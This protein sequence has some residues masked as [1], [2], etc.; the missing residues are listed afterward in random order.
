MIKDMEKTSTSKRILGFPDAFWIGYAIMVAIFL[1]LVFDIQHDYAA[2]TPHVGKWTELAHG[3]A[4]SG[5]LGVIQYYFTYHHLPD[6]SPMGTTG[7]ADPPLFYI[8]CAGIL[9]LIH[10]MGGWA[11]GT[12]LHCISCLNAIFTMIGTFCG[13]GLL[14]KAGIRGRELVAAILFLLFFPAYY[15]LGQRL[16]GDAM[17]FMFC[18]LAL[19]AAAG[20][21][22]TRRKRTLIFASVFYGLGTLTSYAAF[23][24][25]PA[26]IAL[27]VLAVRDGRTEGRVFRSQVIPSGIVAGVMSLVWPVYNLIRFGVPLFYSG[28]PEG[29]REVGSGISFFERVNPLRILLLFDPE[30]VNAVDSGV[31]I[32]LQ[33][34]RSAF[35]SDYLVTFNEFTR[36]LSKVYLFLGIFVILLMHILWIWALFTDS[37]SKPLK[38]FTVVGYVS[39]LIGFVCVCLGIPYAEMADIRFL[40]AIIFFPLL[41]MASMRRRQERLARAFVVTENWAI[42]AFALV[43]AFL[44]GFYA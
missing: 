42:F 43:T 10:R 12:C 5:N 25:L 24:A 15:F 36:A 26:I 39:M 6:F 3:T 17:A 18:S 33:T 13:I 29:F 22:Q 34:A 40:P 21:F 9:E 2:F 14:R 41:G 1:K 30:A 32:P 20:W 7:Y 16:N 27:V 38:I 44:L 35:F 37:M 4:H 19:N 8:F 11:I 31:N 23:A 28:A